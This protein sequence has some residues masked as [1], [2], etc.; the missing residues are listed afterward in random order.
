MDNLKWLDGKCIKASVKEPDA[1]REEPENQKVLSACHGAFGEIRIRLNL[2]F[3][4]PGTVEKPK[5][6]YWWALGESCTL[7]CK[8]VDVANWFREQLKDFVLGLDGVV[9]EVEDADTQ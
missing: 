7:V 1:L 4:G 9:L 3:Y 6:R 8:D 5:P 2:G